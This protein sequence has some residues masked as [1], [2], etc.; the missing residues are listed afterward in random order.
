MLNA[1]VVSDALP[2]IKTLLSIT[3][4]LVIVQMLP[5]TSLM[6]MARHHH[7]DT[8]SNIDNKYININMHQST[9]S[10]KQSDLTLL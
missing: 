8:S 9:Y 4:P 3:I 2:A 6:L 10:Q 5:S 1:A 7:Q